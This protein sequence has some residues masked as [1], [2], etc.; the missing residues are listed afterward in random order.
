MSKQD[1]IRKKKVHCG[2]YPKP[3]FSLVP[4]RH[5]GACG[6]LPGYRAE[7]NDDISACAHGFSHCWSP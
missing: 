6:P 5:C 4:Y 3:C 2:V 1:D 7:Y